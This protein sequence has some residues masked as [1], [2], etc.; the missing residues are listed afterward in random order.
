MAR[1]SIAIARGLRYTKTRLNLTEGEEMAITKKKMLCKKCNLNTAHMKRGSEFKIG[2][3]GSLLDGV[4]AVVSLGMVSTLSKKKS[5]ECLE[6][7]DLQ[8][9]TKEFSVF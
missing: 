3:D 6:C 1:F 7:G 2:D 8:E 9:E 5:W 4:L